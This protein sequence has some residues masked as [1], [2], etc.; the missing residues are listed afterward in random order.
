MTSPANPGLVLLRAACPLTFGSP[1]L[2]T[3]SGTLSFPV[4]KSVT[5]CLGLPGSL[6]FIE[7]VLRGEARGVTCHHSCDSQLLKSS[8][9]VLAQLA[10]CRLCTSV[11][12]VCLSAAP[13]L[14][15]SVGVSLPSDTIQ[16]PLLLVPGSAWLLFLPGVLLLPGF[17]WQEKKT[18]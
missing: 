17:M 16:S 12:D 6:V 2:K 10:G 14:P 8:Q 3:V 4:S 1:G 9:K 5:S 13:D 11:F 15:G 18:K 7:H